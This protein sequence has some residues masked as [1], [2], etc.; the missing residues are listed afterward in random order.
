MM[1]FGKLAVLGAALALL[2]A[3]EVADNAVKPSITGTAPGGADAS[4]SASTPAPMAPVGVIRN[5]DGS[6]TV[7]PLDNSQPDQPTGTA[8][9]QKVTELKSDLAR[10][11]DTLKSQTGRQQALHAD[12]EQN[13]AAYQAI[14]GAIAGKLQVG[15]TPGNPGIVQAWQQASPVIFT[16]NVAR[17]GLI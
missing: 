11:Q 4:A 13:A 6:V 14:T 17:R 10:L 9:G 7:P 16:R 1:G 5:P 12:I 2:S 3:C 8:V 15:T